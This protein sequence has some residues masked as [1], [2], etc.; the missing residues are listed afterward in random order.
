MKQKLTIAL[1]AILTFS[2]ILTG[3]AVSTAPAATAAEEAAGYGYA[4]TTHWGVA[5][6]S[7]S[8]FQVPRFTPWAERD[9]HVTY[10]LVRNLMTE[11]MQVPEVAA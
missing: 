2:L 7:T 11:P 4:V 8:P 5:D 3:C 10:Q 9:W 1:V 6:A